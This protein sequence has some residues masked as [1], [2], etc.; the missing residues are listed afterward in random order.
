MTQYYSTKK[1][2]TWKYIPFQKMTKSDRIINSI[3]DM[4]LPL[5]FSLEDC[6]LIA[7]II[8]QEVERKT[9]LERNG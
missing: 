3:L 8:G 7:T 2:D 6:K 9:P 4:R 1:Y 5:T